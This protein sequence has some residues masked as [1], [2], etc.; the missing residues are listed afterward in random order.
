MWSKAC[1]FKEKVFL[2]LDIDL[3]VEIVEMFGVFLV[4]VASICKEC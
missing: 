2:R 3:T 4:V 1:E